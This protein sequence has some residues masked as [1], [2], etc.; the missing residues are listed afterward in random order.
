M[1]FLSSPD[2]GSGEPLG[3]YVCI[4][5][6]TLLHFS[7]TFN[8][9]LRS[10]SGTGK[11]DS[12]GLIIFNILGHQKLSSLDLNK[13]RESASTTALGKRFQ[14]LTILLVNENFLRS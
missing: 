8:V 9:I 7:K 14:I 12:V 4:I 2:A 13:S 1:Q 6:E 10:I 11:V 3:A 5:L